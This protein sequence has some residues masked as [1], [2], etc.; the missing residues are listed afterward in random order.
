[1]GEVGESGARGDTTERLY[2]YAIGAADIAA[3]AHVATFGGPLIVVRSG[4]LGAVVSRLRSSERAGQGRASRESNND[5]TIAAPAATRENLLRHEAA[6]E[7][8]CAGAAALPV[9][10]GVILPDGAAV[11]QA[12]ARQSDALR[13]DLLRI[14]DKVEVSVIA[15]WNPAAT[16]EEAENGRAAMKSQPDAQSVEQRPGLAY[17]RARQAQYERSAATR[18]RAERLGRA[19]DVE[20][21]PRPLQS[22]RTLCPSQRLALRDV[23]LLERAQVDA[24]GQTFEDARRRHAAEARLLLSGPWPPYSFVS[25]PRP[26]ASDVNI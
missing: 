10:F 11:E 18:A 9:R 7:A 21:R 13:A 17:L 6:V 25:A 22:Q 14:G 3:P 1:M 23:Y 12:L 4:A 15:L 24:F 8:I 26:T 5:S 20:L 16:E 19:L 2:V